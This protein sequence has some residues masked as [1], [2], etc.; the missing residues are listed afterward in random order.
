[1]TFDDVFEN[2]LEFSQESV[3]EELAN[4]DE[5]LNDDSS[6]SSTNNESCNTNPDAAEEALAA[7]YLLDLA[8]EADL[9][10]L[11]SSVE[12]M[13]DISNLMG[14]AMERTIVRFD[15]AARF[16]HLTK[17]AELNAARAKNDPL[18]RKLVKLWTME[19]ALEKQ[20]AQKYASQGK[21]IATQRIKQYAANGKRIVKPHPST[22]SYKD[23]VSTKIGKKAVANSRKLFSNGNKKTSL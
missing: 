12:E 11:A 21:K 6:C 9:S 3:D 10:A 22:V 23:K 7:A 17:Q 14:V 20:I 16:K 2:D 19:R 15:R 4:I 5:E 1:M 18:Y 13:A 8:D